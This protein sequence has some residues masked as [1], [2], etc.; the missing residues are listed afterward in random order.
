MWWIHTLTTGCRSHSGWDS[1][2]CNFTLIKNKTWN[3][4]FV[5]PLNLKMSSCQRHS[6]ETGYIIWAASGFSFSSCVITTVVVVTVT[7]VS[8][9]VWPYSC[10]SSVSP[11]WWRASYHLWSA[12]SLTWRPWWASAALRAQNTRLQHFL[13]LWFTS[14]YCG[15]WLTWE[16]LAEVSWVHRHDDVSFSSR[17]TFSGAAGATLQVEKPNTLILTLHNSK[18]TSWHN[19]LIWSLI[20]HFLLTLESFQWIRMSWS[21]NW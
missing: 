11:V 2:W 19:L 21:T 9:T 1:S 13:F 15:D 18:K 10:G 14:G 6:Q 5:E 8:L 12:A 3:W 16:H 17:L 20:Y 4:W 7:Q